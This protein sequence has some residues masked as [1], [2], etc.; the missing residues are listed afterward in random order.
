LLAPGIAQQPATN[1]EG[2]VHSLF[3]VGVVLKGI[4]AALETVGGLILLLVPSD[5]IGQFIVTITQYQLVQTSHPLFAKA[6]QK[7]IEVTTEHHWWA[8][9]F[10]LSHGSVKLLIIIGM[11]LKKLWAYRVGLVV[12]VGLVV[13]QI[14]HILETHS[15]GLLILTAFDVA[16]IFLAWREYRR[17]RQKRAAVNGIR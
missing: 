15:A 9:L 6:V 1:M 11:V 10:L 12:F 13:Y 4:D 7:S 3:R 2:Y 5:D 14:G 16:F 8:G 17:I